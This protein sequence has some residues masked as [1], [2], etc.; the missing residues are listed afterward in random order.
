MSLHRSYEI[1]TYAH[2][3]WRIESIC[4]DA[5]IAI[6]EAKR[7]FRRGFCLAVRVV[8]ECEQPGKSEAL[9]RTIF[10]TSN[11]EKPKTKTKA[12]AYTIDSAPRANRARAA[13]DHEGYDVNPE[14]HGVAAESVVGPVCMVLLTATIILAGVGAILA[15]RTYF[16]AI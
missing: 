14:T 16:G 4:D 1:Q 6:F 12:R 5:E 9:V 3:A 13:A 10:R 2:G 7:V 11:A 15:L 8:E